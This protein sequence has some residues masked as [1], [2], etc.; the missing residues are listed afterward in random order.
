[1]LN[2]RNFARLQSEL[3]IDVMSHK[4]YNHALSLLISKYSRSLSVFVFTYSLLDFL[5]GIL[6]VMLLLLLGLLGSSGLG[7]RGFSV[8]SHLLYLLEFLSQINYT[9]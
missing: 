6:D 9:T 5:I 3:S 7:T 1:M 4:G 2:F 8:F